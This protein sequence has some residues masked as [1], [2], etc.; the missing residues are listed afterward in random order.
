MPRIKKGIGR[1]RKKNGPKEESL[2]ESTTT[3]E[4]GDESGEEGAESEN[5]NDEAVGGGSCDIGLDD[6]DDDGRGG[7][8]GGD[9]AGGG[10]DG[11]GV[12]DGGGG[13]SSGAGIAIEL[14]NGIIDA[15]VDEQRRLN[16]RFI[17]Y[18]ATAGACA[19]AARVGRGVDSDLW[20]CAWSQAHSEMSSCIDGVTPYRVCGEVGV[21]TVY[22][23]M[24]KKYRCDS[25]GNSVCLCK[26]MVDC[27]CGEWAGK[28]SWQLI[29]NVGCRCPPRRSARDWR[30]FFWGPSQYNWME[31]VDESL[32]AR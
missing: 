11:G 15:A 28:W 2:N 16:W 19:E 25:C 1:K 6:D 22:G 20:E 3:V 24:S 27:I 30:A 21:G 5:G 29:E 31:S 14:I 26:C 8:G 17:K 10:D 9:S 32:H 18:A 23:L 13:S 12:S 4:G 7:I